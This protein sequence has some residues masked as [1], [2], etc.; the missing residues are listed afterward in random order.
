MRRHHENSY[1]WFFFPVDKKMNTIGKKVAKMLPI[2]KYNLSR[3]R[4]YTKH[5]RLEETI[6]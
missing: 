5:T 4:S 3:L 6:F 2:Q 1:N